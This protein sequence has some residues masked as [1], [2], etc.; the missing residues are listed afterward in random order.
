MEGEGKNI[1]LQ[2]VKR[3]GMTSNFSRMLI[4]D[5]VLCCDLK[6][7]EDL[8]AI[9]VSFLSLLSPFPPHSIDSKSGSET[10]TKLQPQN[11]REIFHKFELYE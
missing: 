10:A 11:L 5:I 3:A 9:F 4:D 2:T 6:E 1:I 8:S 7:E